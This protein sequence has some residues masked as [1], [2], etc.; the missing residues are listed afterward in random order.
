M[1]NKFINNYILSVINTLAGLLIP[2]ITFPYVSRVLGAENLGIINFAAS[3]GYYFM[4]LA[5]FGIS[6]YA[7]REISKIRDNK[8]ELHRVSN[9][10]YNINILFSILSG[11]L[12]IVGVFSI[13]KFREN[14]LVFC[15]YSLPIFTNFLGL[16]WIFQAFDDYKFT[17]LRGLL[18]RVLSLVATFVFIKEK[19]DY[20]IYMLISAISDMGSRLSN[21][22]YVRKRYAK[23]NLHPKFLNFKKHFKSLF[24]LFIFRMI[25][26]ISANLDKIM[27]GFMLIYSYV[28]VYSAGIKFVL[29]VIPLI[30]NIGIVLF[31]KINISA[32]TSEDEYKRNL[33]FNYNLILM[34]SIPMAVGMF[35]LSPM[36]I[37]LFAGAE[38]LGAINVSRIM[39]LII[40]LC[41]IGDLLG[42]KTLLVYNKDS[43]LLICSSIVAVSNI[44]LNAVFIPLWGINGATFASLMSY[45]VAVL[46]RYIFTRRLVKFNL[47][48]WNLLKYTCFTVPFIIIYLFLRDYINSNVGIMFAY[49]FV[50]IIIYAFELFFTKDKDFM[51]VIKRFLKK[52]KKCL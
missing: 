14:A 15:L 25:N 45:F 18:V 47:F 41:P 50:A 7:I 33:N 21:L 31:P 46:S 1:P 48:T 26:G 16:E 28:G 12:Y 39:C 34:L 3:Y 10:I 5:N 11:V 23:I 27:I 6:S 20:P 51:F 40:V 30:E 9:E 49:V 8:D 42:S 52:D 4:H 44:V 38:Y 32:G 29:L 17:T 22:Y 24:T 19:A 43:W 37:K 35:L 13:A 36:I 2:I